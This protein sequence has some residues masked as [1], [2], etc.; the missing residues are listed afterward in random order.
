MVNEV[1][2]GVLQEEYVSLGPSYLLV[3]Q[4]VHDEVQFVE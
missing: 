4:N 3:E 2:S 1:I